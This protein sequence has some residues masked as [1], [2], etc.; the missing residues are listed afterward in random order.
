M[1]RN[2]MRLLAVLLAFALVA[3][4]CGGDDDDSAGDDGSTSSDDG[5]DD[6]A[7]PEPEPEGDDGAE[8][9]PEPEGDDGA[10]PEPEPEPEEEREASDI[11][12]TE[13][14]IKIGV[15]VADLD[16]LRDIG[17]PLPEALTTEHLVNRWS[18]YF[19]D[20][21]ADGG[22]NG[23]MVEAVPLT[24]DPLSPETMEN[25]CVQGT[26]DEE[27]FM[28]VNASGFSQVF[29]PCFTEDNDMFFFYGETVPQSMIDRAPNR[30]FA[31]NPPAEVAGQ[32]GAELAVAQNLIPEGA[33]VGILGSNN[34]AVLQAAGS[35]T[36]ILEAAGFETTVVEVN[37]LSDDNSAIN[38][39]SAAAVST[40]NAEGVGHVFVTMGF[41]TAAG[42]WGEV[43]ALDPEWGTTL[44]DSSSANCTPFGASRTNPAAAGAVCVTS[45][46]SYG[47]P[48]G[49]LSD[50][51]AY[52]AECRQEWVDHFPIFEGNSDKGVPSGEVALEDVD[53]NLLY[54]DFPPGEC[55]MTDLIREAL[56]NAGINPTRDSFADALRQ[57]SGSQAFRSNGEGAFGDGKNYYSTQM[58]AAQFTL[59]D[60]ETPRGEDGT[61]NGCPAPTNCWIPVTGDWFEI[62][63]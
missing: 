1:S 4:A 50:D 41:T 29:I 18:L 51:D 30:L 45:Y 44:I 8:P 47:L 2:L 17:F 59:V 26:L 9:E 48:G 16:P 21:N 40:F 61:Y 33:K 15:L 31:L 63:G 19:D 39:E 12:I 46:D 58:W 13:D 28:V 27:L 36:E 11:G 52:E 53:G 55:T 23:R 56:T 37:T 25:A 38:Q 60:A 3:A 10:E 54:S 24:W 43:G 49:G 22:L 62:Q 6:G 34:P 42:F 14:T 7:E 57:L 35:A 5:G 20:W 32:V